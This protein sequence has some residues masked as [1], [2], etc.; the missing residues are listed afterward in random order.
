MEDEYPVFKG[1]A[2]IVFA[3]VATAKKFAETWPWK[4]KEFEKPLLGEDKDAIAN[5]R[6]SGFRSLPM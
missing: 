3:E 6:R 5:A 4:D 2:F 1:F